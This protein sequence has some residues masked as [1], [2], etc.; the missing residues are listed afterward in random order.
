M[1]TLSLGFM[2]Q[3]LTLMEVFYRKGMISILLTEQ[4]CQKPPQTHPPPRRLANSRLVVGQRRGS[5]PLGFSALSWETLGV[6]PEVDGVWRRK[7]LQWGFIMP[8]PP[9][10]LVFSP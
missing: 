4:G 10:G 2:P 9:K 3:N 5:A 6:N 1:L 8:Y 7:G